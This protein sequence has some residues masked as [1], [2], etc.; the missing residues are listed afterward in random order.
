MALDGLI[1]FVHDKGAVLA[2]A[3][4]D[5]DLHATLK[6]EG[7]LKVAQCRSFLPDGR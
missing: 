4:L 7:V 2:L 3:G 6:Q 5:P 1:A